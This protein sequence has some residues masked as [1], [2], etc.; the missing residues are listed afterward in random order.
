MGI[1]QTPKPGTE[2]SDKATFQLL[3]ELEGR[4]TALVQRMETEISRSGAITLESAGELHSLRI[5]A[6]RLFAKSRAE[7]SL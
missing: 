7:S 6:D 4:L 2:Q 5:E 1:G 3:T